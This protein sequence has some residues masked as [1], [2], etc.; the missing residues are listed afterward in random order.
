M[1]AGLVLGLQALLFIVSTSSIVI[2]KLASVLWTLVSGGAAIKILNVAIGGLGYV[3]GQLGMQT[4]ALK[5][6]QIALTSGMSLGWKGV[7]AT[8][9]QVPKA[10]DLIGKGA[11]TALAK[12]SGAAISTATSAVS[13]IPSILGTVMS[14][15]GKV[16]SVATTHTSKLG[17]GFVGL[18]LT[19]GLVAKAGWAMGTA[20]G[21]SLLAAGDKV[22]GVNDATRDA[23]AKVGLLKGAWILLGDVFK[24][25]PGQVNALYHQLFGGIA[26][27]IDSI[28]IKL[29]NTW[30]GA[31]DAV[32]KKASEL[33][34][35]FYDWALQQYGIEEINKKI[36]NSMYEQDAAGKRTVLTMSAWQAKMK[37]IH[38]EIQ[39]VDAAL[40]KTSEA[41]KWTDSAI[42]AKLTEQREA[43]VKEN[44]G[45]ALGLDKPLGDL[46][47]SEH[48]LAVSTVEA[49]RAQERQAKV[50]FALSGGIAGAARKALEAAD[51]SARQAQIQEQLRAA[52]GP[53]QAG[54]IAKEIEA[55]KKLKAALAETA[56]Q[57]ASNVLA[58]KGLASASVTAA[59]PASL[60]ALG[61][62]SRV[63]EDQLAGLAEQIGVA[64]ASGQSF[65][66]AATKVAD[67]VVA[68]WLRFSKAT[69]ELEK[70]T[71][72]MEAAE[73]RVKT[74]NVAFGIGPDIPGMQDMMSLQQ[75]FGMMAQRQGGD[76][77]ALGDKT[78]LT[79][80][81]AVRDASENAAPAAKEIGD[82]LITSIFGDL[83]SSGKITA[84]ADIVTK[85]LDEIGDKTKDGMADA[86]TTG[87]EFFKQLQGHGEEA[88][89]L[90]VEN[91]DEAE[92]LIMSLAPL[93][94]EL[95]KAVAQLI[96]ARLQLEGIKKIDWAG[97]FSGASEFFSSLSASAGDAAD[98][99]SQSLSRI[100]KTIQDVQAAGGMGTSKGKGMAV[101]GALSAAGSL[102]S[103]TSKLGGA[104]SGAGAG[105]A[106]GTMIA[107]G[108]GTAIGG[109]VG[110]IG[111]LIGASKKAKEEMKQLKEQFLQ[112]VG[113]L[114]QLE[115]T[116]KEAGISL[117]KMFKAKNAKD[118]EKAIVGI[119][120]KLQNWNEANAALQ[121]AIDKYGFTIEELG[122]KFKQQRLDEMAGELLQDY[123]LLTASGIDVNTVIQKMS[124]N[125]NEYIQTAL[126]AGAQI[127]IAMKPVI[128]AMILNGT[129]LDENG[130]AY[131]SA[132]AA[133]I[134]YAQTMSDMF[135]SLIE[136]I[137]T[138]VNALLGI[139]DR[140]VNV[141]TVYTDT[142]RNR[143]NP[144]NPDGD[145]ENTDNATHR[146]SP[147]YEA[148]TGFHAIVR[149]PTR[150]LVGE[151]GP[152]RVDVTPRGEQAPG[153]GSS[154]T[155][156]SSFHIDPLQSNAARGD[157]GK[158]LVKQFFREARNN[159]LMKKVLREGQRG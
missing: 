17:L 13:K 62:A 15:I 144:D 70:L 82:G 74:M 111:G 45:K 21:S 156:N 55:Q 84:A 145:S 147:D 81:K 137:D 155:F 75:S 104:L 126:K 123:K 142:F 118:L 30:V 10:F 151:A 1:V 41:A 98:R 49:T 127:P 66:A 29:N 78:I 23:V 19:M 33:G 105:A 107:P 88:K 36:V 7:T 83:T 67:D 38:D 64:R 57:I 119:Q 148:A 86:A 94:P 135:T 112:S 11:G 122:P 43:A 134:T 40:R 109:V 102:F 116:A 85:Y 133:G 87:T 46:A 73:D 22:R 91:T 77:K 99:I 152:E 129:L 9:A 44:A 159:P 27:W 63:T 24:G 100:S 92:K 54:Y 59:L 128:D 56:S 146:T 150:L 114:K 95:A 35:L 51:Q 39:K 3:L 154:V 96:K 110:A 61:D 42:V 132:E 130:N 149:R 131:A 153:G 80:M 140:T 52:A 79:F 97:V 158:F 32:A 48:V 124:P 157:L 113:G 93:S 28:A 108:I 16:I 138:L 115:A 18:S 31:F 125:M 90:F 12:V 76:M 5:V 136:R 60:E 34:D 65:S 103:P 37:E 2:L 25:I 101:A 141:N 26:D 139:P 120:E 8:L 143:P 68:R 47:L 58:W 117:D 6:G 4:A 14:G 53:G 50:V 89:Q 69:E 72:A 106:I 71:E 121:E 20:L